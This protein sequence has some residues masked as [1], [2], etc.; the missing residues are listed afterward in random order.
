MLQFSGKSWRLPWLVW[1][2]SALAP[3][4]TFIQNLI[5]RNA[6]LGGII[7]QTGV[8]RRKYKLGSTKQVFLGH[9]VAPHCVYRVNHMLRIQSRFTIAGEPETPISQSRIL[10]QRVCD[11]MAGKKLKTAAHGPTN[12]IVVTSIRNKT[13]I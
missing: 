2:R 10:L 7:F 4:D 9:T 1:E 13:R 12:N 6:P 11:S 5:V 8:R 3:T